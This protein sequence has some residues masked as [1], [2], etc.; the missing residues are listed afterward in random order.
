MMTS[1]PCVS[2]IISSKAISAIILFIVSAI[3]LH[4]AEPPKP[5]AP[6][7]PDAASLFRRDNLIAWC[8]VPFDA[9]KRGPEERAE[10]L[11]RLG[12]KHFAYDYR[13]EHVPTFDAEVAALKRHNVSLDAWWF[14]SSLNNEA[15]QILDVCKRHGITP[16]LWITGGGAPTSS[17]EEQQK[18][19]E[20]E[21]AR[22]RPI[23][24]AAAELGCKVGLYNH[25]GWFGEPENQLAIIEQLK[26]PNVGIIYNQHHGHDHLDRFAEL[27]KKMQPHLLA[28][29]LNGMVRGGDKAGRKILQLGQGDLDLE[30]LKT[31]RDSGYRGPIGILGHTQDDAEAR[32][33]DNL[34]GLDWLVPQLDGHPAAARPKPRTPVPGAAAQKSA[35][36]SPVSGYLAE[37]RAEYRTL[38]LTVQLR[39]TLRGKQNYNI[40]AACDTK[41]SG[42]HWELFSMPGTG[43]LTAYLPGYQPDHVRSNVDICDSQPHDVAMVFEPARVRLYIDGKLAADTVV[44]AKEK[45]VIPGG[46]AF[47]R[48]V[49]G[50]IGCN[51][52]LEYVH[53]ARGA[54]EIAPRKSPPEVD[55]NTIGYWRFEKADSAEIPDSSTFKN[56]AKR[57]AAPT[58]NATSGSMP[59]AGVHLSST[60]PRLK[61]VLIDRSPADVYMGVKVDTAGRVFVGGREAVFVFEPDDRGGYGPKRELLRF[62]NDSIIMGLEFRGNDLYVL[63]SNALYLVPDGRVQREGLKPQRILWGLPLDLHVSFHCLAWGPEGDLYL[64]HGDPLLNFGDWSRADHWGHWTL[65]AG[66]KSEPVPYTGQGCVLRVR[67]DGSNPHVV[68]TGL[69]GP[70]GLC[71][72]KHWNLF[73]ND[74]DHESRADQ[75]APMRLL[76]ATQ[77]IDFAWPRGWM[78]SKSPDRADLIEPMSPSLG[79]GVP[80]DSTYYDDA[81]LADSI[82]GRLLLCRWDR[83][84]VTSYSLK[85][86]GASFAVEE[87]TLLAGANNARPVGIAVGRDGRLFV[88]SLYM[89]GNMASPYCASDLVMVTRADDAANHPFE[90]RDLATAPAD[91]L[92]QDLSDISWHKRSQAHQEILRRGKTTLDDAFQRAKNVSDEDPAIMH[93]PHLCAINNSEET[94]SQLSRFAQDPRA[95]V[96]LQ[97]VRAMSGSPSKFQATFLQTALTDKDAAIRLAAMGLFEPEFS[98]PAALAEIIRAGASDDT[99]LRQTAVHTLARIASLDDLTPLLTASDAPTRLTAVLA[100]GH[101]LTVPAVRGI[102]PTQVQLSYP[103]ESPFFKAAQHFYGEKEPVDLATL[104][105]IGSYTTAQAWA[106]APRSAEQDAYFNLLMRALDDSSDRVR[107]QA[108]YFLSLLNDSRSEPLVTR[109][110]SDVTLRRLSQ[111]PVQRIEQAWSLGP[112]DTAD[113]QLLANPPERGAIDLT[114]TYTSSQGPLQWK[115]LLAKDGKF[116]WSVDNPSAAA[117]STYLYLR[118]QSGQRHNARLAVE[119]AG[120]VSVW[121]NGANVEEL[122][123]RSSNSGTQRLIDLEPGSND[124]LLRLDSAAS[125]D[126]CVIRVQA[127]GTVTATIPEKLDSALLGQRLRDAAGS[128][129]PLGTE[130]TA[131]NWSQEVQR[132]D[133]AAGRKLFGTLGC[134]KCHAVAAEQKGAGAPSLAEARRRFTVPHLVE[135]ILLPSRQ[136]A[137]PFRA[138]SIVT[139]EGQILTGLVTAETAGTIDVLLPDASRRTLQKSQIDERTPTALSPMPQGI[140]KTPDELRHLLSYLLS[141]RPLPP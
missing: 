30:L 93:L 36:S 139:T 7:T 40:L 55:A 113:K 2:R 56:P 82:P 51:G 134:A 81:Y 6:P 117:T 24:E 90:A 35:T 13:A 125:T 23:A 34:D 95:E 27:L 110:R 80:C 60:D 29:N 31:I 83:S 16:Q 33:Q 65:F 68:A 66:P 10:M 97:A 45:P 78:A 127:N 130:F 114:A 92:W 18:R 135:S 54:H 76:H 89:T 44:Q 112:A 61:V 4:A 22:I 140:V 67:P 102:P 126:G 20:T 32:L 79:R 52:T 46:L 71:F 84:A 103:K 26:L 129:Q 11:Q 137:E 104:G 121:H 105:R 72:D 107:L 17:P 5:N 53:L 138:S 109:T 62:P 77:G 69:R 74:N 75:Y 106:S 42:S 131:V 132:G 14:P 91:R 21:T 9:K 115:T 108:A 28:L 25:G 100:L 8:I 96:R 118:L 43:H 19:I 124:L 120:K 12:F 73:T 88:T 101:K 116:S 123:S 3:E 85:P 94:K 59:P 87:S 119:G 98:S 133:A 15:K 49:E 1:Y 48:V 47:G 38:P 64:T 128:T 39:A 41:A 50:N 37:G 122:A 57:T 63:T 111:A 58:A 136:V 86:Q 141:E 70:V 99:Y